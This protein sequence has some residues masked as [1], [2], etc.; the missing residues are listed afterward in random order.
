[1]NA[2]NVH[3]RSRRR[4]GATLLLLATCALAATTSAQSNTEKA[5]GT[6]DRR[7]SSAD[8]NRYR[9]IR[10]ARDWRNPYLMIGADGITVRSD[11]LPSGQMT[12]AAVNLRRTLVGLPVI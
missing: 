11:S 4:N 8:R 10:D 7:I 5:E 2:G 6:L 9:S 1:M 12:V 3:Y